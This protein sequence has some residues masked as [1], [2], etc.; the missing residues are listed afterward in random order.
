MKEILSRTLKQ[1]ESYLVSV[2]PRVQLLSE[3][4][5]NFED[6]QEIAGLI[7]QE[8]KKRPNLQQ[9]TNYLIRDFPV[10]FVAFLAVFAAQNTETRLLIKP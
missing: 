4:G 2:M 1:W 10:T 8:N 6:M 5:L 3:I 7:R 9:T